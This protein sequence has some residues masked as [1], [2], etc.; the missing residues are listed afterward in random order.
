MQNDP[1]PGKLQWQDTPSWH[2][3]LAKKEDRL[4]RDSGGRVGIHAEHPCP[5]LVFLPDDLR[6][7]WA[8]ARL[9]E[10]AA[11]LPQMSW[12]SL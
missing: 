8:Y 4:S 12:R 9:A 2:D 5:V 7:S 6:V 10:T 1:E 11:I 3:S